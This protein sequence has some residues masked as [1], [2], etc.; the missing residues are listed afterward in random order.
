[1]E[2]VTRH[3][4]ATLRRHLSLFPAVAVTGPRQSGKTTMLRRSFPAYSYVSFD[5]PDVRS[6]FADDPKG[7]MRRHAGRTV[8]DEVQKCPEI[9]EYL[10]LEIDREREYGRFLLTGSSQFGVVRGIVESLAGR[11]G[12]LSLLPFQADEVPSVSLPDLLLYGGYPEIVSRRN[13]GAR[14]WFSAYVAN[15]VERDVRMIRDIGN[16]RDFQNVMRL[17]AARSA[18]ELNSSS[19]SRELGVSVKTVQAWISVLEASYVVFLLPPFHRNLGKRIVKRPK[20]YFWDTGLA[21]H[22]AGVRSREALEEGPMAGALFENFA[23]A[24]TY[25]GILH[26]D[27]DSSLFYFRTNAGLEAD[28]VLEDRAAR[29]VDFIEVKRSETFRPSMLE[30][31]RVLLSA[32]GEQTG[33]RGFRCR[34]KVVYGG[35]ERLKLSGDMEAEGIAAFVGRK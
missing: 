11:C 18:Q 28:L 15:Y 27:R 35:K 5:D 12:F 2:Y 21:C 30:N 29:R 32:A 9:F 33:G 1:M 3:C 31:L 23:V 8:F 10:K 20:L 14:E 19:I 16:L 7:F 34:G 17:L 22:L 26:G 24:E 6:L 4:E 13:A 25:K